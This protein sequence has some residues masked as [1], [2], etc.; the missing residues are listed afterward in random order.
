MFTEALTQVLDT[1]LLI[2]ISYSVLNRTSGDVQILS[3]CYT[4]LSVNDLEVCVTFGDDCTLEKLHSQT[5][6]EHVNRNLEP[7]SQT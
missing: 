7:M 2:K 3:R 4:H 6:T 5:K 1:E